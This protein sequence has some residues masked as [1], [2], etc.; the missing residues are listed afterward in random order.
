MSAHPQ[1]EA[2]ALKITPLHAL[3]REM[4]ARM[5]AFGGYDMPIQYPLG[6]LKEHLHTRSA[7]GLFDVSHMGQ[8]VV[9]PRSGIMRDAV[10]A[11]EAIMP[12]DVVAI[13]PGRQRYAMFTSDAGG[14]LDDL[15]VSHCGDYY[16]LVVNASRKYEDETLLAAALASTCIVERC[17]DRA[18]I[19]L[20]GP[21]AET[22]LGAV[23]P[24]AKFM[25]FMDIQ[26]VKILD[27][28]CVVARSGYTGEDGFE[29]SIPAAAV[30]KIAR[31]L[32]E[33]PSVA[34]IGLGARD[35]LRLEAGLCLYGS[36]IDE[37]TSPVEA[38]LDWAIQKARRP[39]GD[40]AG[41]FPG[42]EVIMPQFRAG[43]D[44]V[45]VGLTPVV[46]SPVR[47]G[48]QIFS[49]ETSQT[50]I[51]IVTS[52]GFGPTADA[53]VAMGYVDA[54]TAR[55]RPPIYADVRGKRTALLIV[56]LPFVKHRYRR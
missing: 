3:H 23:C 27:T 32:L 53:F 21:A 40:R 49:D 10:L 8:F 15:M 44:R 1:L 34:L 55:A 38:S 20:Q 46:K 19:A 4:G 16:L 14:I 6:I 11:L 5:A 41:G 47:S 37:A 13:A 7:A 42:A 48:A 45:R 25:K 18:L 36:D 12:I 22:V 29:I 2:A 56:D 31:A 26:S 17:D 50:P 30:E 51:G 35:S 28:D 54:A 43:T 9:R 24:T 33:Q 39:G 52:G